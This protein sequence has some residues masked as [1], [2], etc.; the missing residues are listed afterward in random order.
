MTD[1]QL[2]GAAAGDVADEWAD[3]L[4][5]ASDVIAFD[6]L[7]SAVA[8]DPF[9]TSHLDDCLPGAGLGPSSLARYER[10]SVAFLKSCREMEQDHEAQ[11]IL[12]LVTAYWLRKS[13]P[14][15]LD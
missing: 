6:V 2:I 12:R 10:A 8:E 11:E 15:W 4:G 3:P 14:I 7:K 1:I 13:R 9:A 5:F